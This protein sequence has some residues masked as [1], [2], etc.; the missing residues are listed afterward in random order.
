M[1]LLRWDSNAFRY[2]VSP[3]D[4]KPR[5][6]TLTY[7]VACFFIPKCPWKLTSIAASTVALADISAHSRHKDK[8]VLEENA[9]FAH[10][11]CRHVLCCIWYAIISLLKSQRKPEAARQEMYQTASSSAPTRHKRARASV[12][13][14]PNGFGYFKHQ[15]VQ[16]GMS[17]LEA[18]HRKSRMIAQI[19]HL[20]WRR[21]MKIE[22]LEGLYLLTYLNLLFGH[23]RRLFVC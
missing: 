9:F 23:V 12:Q 14:P 11:P 8:K 10:K 20:E 17:Q 4:F 6:Q 13:Q 15:D 18:G 1:K 19:E 7:L 2:R 21:R 3:Q 16:R 22:P 5:F